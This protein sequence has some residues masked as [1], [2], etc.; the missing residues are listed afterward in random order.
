[1][2][3]LLHSPRSPRGA[4]QPSQYELYITFSGIGRKFS[5]ELSVSVFSYKMLPGQEPHVFPDQAEI[6]EY[7]YI[8]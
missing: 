4:R 8:S 1:M 2:C 6:A 7:Y 5:H 3:F